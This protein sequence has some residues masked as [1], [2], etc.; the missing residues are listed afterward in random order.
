MA[1]NEVLNRTFLMR[2]NCLSSFPGVNREHV[3]RNTLRQTLHL[4][5][6]ENYGERFGKRGFQ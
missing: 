5:A 1:E 2:E 6:R 4:T 3:N